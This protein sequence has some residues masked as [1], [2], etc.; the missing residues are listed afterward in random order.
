MRKI[1]HVDMDAF[2]A[3]VEQRDEPSY[4]NKPVVV[5][6]S[7][8]G[9]GVVA[10]ASYEARKYGIRSAMPAIRAIKKC[11]HAIFVKPRFDVYKEVSQQIRAIF[12][13]YTDLVEPLSLDEAYLDVTH[14]FIGPPSATLI[15]KEIKHKIR[16]RLNLVAS[17]GVSYNKFLAKIASDLDKPDGLA[18]ILPE[19]AQAFLRS[20]PIG[21]FYGV[22]QATARKMEKLGIRIGE[23]LLQWSES[24]LAA[25]FGKAGHQYYYLVRGIDDR[26]VKPHRIRKSVGKE[27]TFAEDVTDLDWIRTFLIELAGKVAESLQR[28]DGG[29]EDSGGW[30]DEDG[31]V[32]AEGRVDAGGQMDGVGQADRVGQTSVGERSNAREKLK[33]AGRTITLK[34]RYDDFETVTRSL[35]LMDYTNNAKDIA[36]TAV[37]LL[38]ETQA[39]VRPV[40]LLGISVSSLNLE[41][42]GRVGK[43]IEIPFH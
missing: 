15:A 34:V 37:A 29:R 32:Y 41:K 6:G 16:T 36:E 19:E 8:Q 30:V 12:D 18:V 39:G 23:D 1:I 26:D 43:Q 11:P 4:R 17:A 14:P 13:E 28:V 21:K 22:G 42:S 35:T 25:A 3:S 24:D 7:P 27:R 31:R 33:A 10:A 38:K 2:Y 9:R 20:L 40:R 5:G